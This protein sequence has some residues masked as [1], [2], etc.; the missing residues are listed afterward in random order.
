[1]PGLTGLLLE[2]FID[3][4]YT[5][6]VKSNRPLLLDPT[7][8][9]DN[10][11]NRPLL[12]AADENAGE[13]AGSIEEYTALLF[14][15]MCAHNCEYDSMLSTCNVCCVMLISISAQALLCQH[16]MNWVAR[17]RMVVKEYHGAWHP[18]ARKVLAAWHCAQACY[19][20]HAQYPTNVQVVMSM[21]RAQLYE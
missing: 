10:A 15:C 20:A 19:T 16:G 2:K 8:P 12:E 18:E 21:R 17:S 1:V 6:N 11:N 9:I 5:N 7:R 13:E 3:K 14:S 4:H